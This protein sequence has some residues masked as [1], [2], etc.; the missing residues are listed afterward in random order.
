[1]TQPG[2]DITA[3]LTGCHIKTLVYDAGQPIVMVERLAFVPVRKATDTDHG[4]PSPRAAHAPARAPTCA[5]NSLVPSD[6]AW[7]PS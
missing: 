4:R 5:G 6:S 1:M 3:I 7:Q 2:G